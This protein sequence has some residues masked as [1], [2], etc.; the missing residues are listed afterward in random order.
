MAV[1]PTTANALGAP[2]SQRRDTGLEV[3]QEED[4][5][6]GVVDDAA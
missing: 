1:R 3:V 2:P 5:I 6:Q 4:G